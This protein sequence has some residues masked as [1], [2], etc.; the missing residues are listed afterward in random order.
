M[1]KTRTTQEKVGSG[2]KP[3]HVSSSSKGPFLG[4]RK[5]RL[6][7]GRVHGYGTSMRARYVSV[8]SVEKF[9]AET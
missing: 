9:A 6:Q 4:K 7:P 2:A 1:Q 3:I 5:L 8:L